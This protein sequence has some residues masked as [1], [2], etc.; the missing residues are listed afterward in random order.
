MTELDNFFS[1]PRILVF[2]PFFLAGYHFERVGLRRSK[3]K[4]AGAGRV[5]PLSGRLPGPCPYF[6]GAP[7]TENLLRKIFLRGDGHRVRGR[8]SGK[9]GLL[10]CVLPGRFPHKHHNLQETPRL[11]QTR[12]AYHAYLSVPWP[13]IQ[14]AERHAAFG[15][16]VGNLAGHSADCFLPDALMAS[17]HGRAEPFRDKGF[18]L[19]CSLLLRRRIRKDSGH[20][21]GKSARFRQKD[22]KRTL[23]VIT[24][25]EKSCISHIYTDAGNAALCF[26]MIKILQNVI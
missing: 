7:D 12:A 23:R 18:L 24:C 8:D 14:C 21:T 20:F 4:P 22:K 5:F 15:I 9:A 10:W 16:R 26:M 1:I 19:S 6:P 3:K 17:V 25:A 11:F 13:C 2:F